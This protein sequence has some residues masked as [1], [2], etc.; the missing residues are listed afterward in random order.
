MRIPLLGELKNTI[1]LLF[2]DTFLSDLRDSRRAQ[3]DVAAWQQAGRP[4]PPPELV[5]R[6]TLAEF[7]AAFHLDTFIETGTLFGGSLYALKHR[8]KTLYSIELSPE[9]AEKTRHRFRSTP[10]IHI[11]QGDSGTVLPELLEKVTTPCLFW[12]DGH[13]SGGITAQSDLDTPILKEL[14]AILDHPCKEHV[15]LIDD[16]RMFNGTHDYPTIDTLR[17][18]F[19]AQRPND[20]FSVANDAIRIHPSKSVTTTY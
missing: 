2:K 5:K 13:Y 19:A 12:L 8:F 16:A 18:L 1:R 17:Q 20:D 14:Q 3:R 6:V 11:L 4:V 7:G 9:L 15:I 10:H